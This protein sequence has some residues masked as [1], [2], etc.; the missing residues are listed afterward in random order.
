[1]TEFV[2]IFLLANG[3]AADPAKLPTDAELTKLLAGN[4]WE[5]EHKLANGDVGKGVTGY[6]ADG[7]FSGYAVWKRT[8]DRQVGLLEVKI[9]GT[10]KVMNGLLIETVET[11]VP[12]TLLQKGHTTKDKILAADAKS[13]TVHGP[14]LVIIWAILNLPRTLLLVHFWVAQRSARLVTSH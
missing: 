13:V 11:C 4:R 5:E 6:R 2:L 3:V 9:T 14:F 1:M 7:K 12:P 10:W 8:V